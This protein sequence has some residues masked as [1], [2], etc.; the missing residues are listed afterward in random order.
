MFPNGRKTIGSTSLHSF[1]SA[2]GAVPGMK[3]MTSNLASSAFNLDYERAQ[4]SQ[5]K[6]RPRTASS[7]QRFRLLL[8]CFGEKFNL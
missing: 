3:V 1:R 6:V 5:S 8:H 2:A 4:K 7:L